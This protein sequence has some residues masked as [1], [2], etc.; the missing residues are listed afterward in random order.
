MCA[1]QCPSRRPYQP[2]HTHKPR[3]GGYQ[4]PACETTPPPTGATP[5]RGNGELSSR[6]HY[7]SVEIDAPCR[8]LVIAVVP[9]TRTDPGRGDLWSP[10]NCLPAKPSRTPVVLTVIA[11]HCSPAFSRRGQYIFYNSKKYAIFSSFC[12]TIKISRYNKGARSA[13]FSLV[14]I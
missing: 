8:G 10:A 13:G 5:P 14:C 6:A 7:T 9:H 1:A 12:C 4:P 11:T 2:A 3:R